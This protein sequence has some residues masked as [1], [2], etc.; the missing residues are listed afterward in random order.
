M[1][2]EILNLLKLCPCF[3][4]INEEKELN[5]LWI[6]RDILI[7]NNDNY[8]KMWKELP[9]IKKI[10]SSSSLTSLQNNA[11]LTQK[12]PMLNLI[13]QV[14][15]VNGYIMNPIRKSDGYDKTGK[16]QY[17]RYFLIKKQL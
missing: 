14:L 10:Y 12:W 17:K 4:N 1:E 2:V 9:H 11:T 5:G 15:K 13:R 6:Q 16:K 7:H 3:E 8:E